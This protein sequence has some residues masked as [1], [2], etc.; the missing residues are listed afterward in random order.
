[1]AI[2][3]LLILV[4]CPKQVSM[5]L[6]TLPETSVPGGQTVPTQTLTLLTSIAFVAF[7]AEHPPSPASLSQRRREVKPQD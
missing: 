2:G 1:M 4:P 7:L 6:D 5:L 3:K